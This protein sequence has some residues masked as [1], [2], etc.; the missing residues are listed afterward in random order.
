MTKRGTRLFFLGGTLAA[1]LVLLVLTVDSHRQF[2]RLTHADAITPAVDRGQARVAP[3]ELH[4]LPH[5]A[6]RGR[7]LRA[8][9]DEDHRAARCALPAG[10]PQGP[11]EV[12]LRGARPAAH[13]EPP[14]LIPGD[15][16]GHRVPRLG[17]EDRQ[18]GLAAA[19]H[20]GLRRGR[21][22]LQCRRT[23]APRRSRP[24]RPSRERRSSGRHRRAA[25]PATRW[26]PG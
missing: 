7:L 3:Q 10:V 16:R 25:S 22:R 17:G 13:A 14:A 26:L 12:L 2:P 11:L 4:Q 8:R 20:P 1:T 15:R 21:A 9:P 23:R 5:A 6:R 24:T 19:A 18:P